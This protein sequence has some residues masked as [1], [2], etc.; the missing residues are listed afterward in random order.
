MVSGHS[1]CANMHE[2]K[3]LFP[4]RFLDFVV[5]GTKSEQPDEDLRQD[6]P[7]NGPTKC[8]VKVVLVQIRGSAVVNGT[9]KESKSVQAEEGNLRCTCQ[10]GASDTEHDRCEES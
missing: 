3:T 9:E 7:S 5:V 4:M 6:H 1:I 10:A 2:S 8:V